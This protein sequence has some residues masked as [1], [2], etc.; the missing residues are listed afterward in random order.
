MYFVINTSNRELVLEDIN[1]SLGKR[2]GI[3]LDK[4]VGRAKAESSAHLKHSIKKGWIKVKQ[5]D[6]L[7]KPT[8][9]HKEVHVH[10]TQN[11]GVDEA[12]IAK[13]KEDLTKEIK[14]QLSQNNSSD[15]LMQMMQQMMLQMKQGMVMQPGSEGMSVEDIELDPEV[16]ADIHAKAVSKLAGDIGGKRIE[17]S[18]KQVDDNLDQTVDDLDGLI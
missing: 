6:N 17:T 3:D 12:T 8:T 1:T 15:Q 5:K 7:D 9:V 2:Q 4:T 14:E 10:N 13:L 18:K 16:L 11:A